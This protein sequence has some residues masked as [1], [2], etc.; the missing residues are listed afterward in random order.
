MRDTG[1]FLA[2]LDAEGAVCMSPKTESALKAAKNMIDRYGDQ[3]MT[4]TELRIS[5]LRARGQ[6]QAE[7]LWIE[8]RDAL[9]FLL[10]D[11]HDETR[12]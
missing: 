10:E 5:E 12:Q 7:A 1:K 6:S 4:E 8:I 3:A 11:G 9:R 2:S